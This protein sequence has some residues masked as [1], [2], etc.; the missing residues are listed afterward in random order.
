MNPNAQ[1]YGHGVG[2]NIHK[3]E[4]C[5]KYRYKMMGKDKYK[6]LCEDNIRKVAERHNIK[7]RELSVMPE[8]VHT[9]VE[10]P[11]TMS[12]VKAQQ[13]LKGG[14]S[15]EIFRAQPKFRLRYPRGSFWRRGKSSNTIG[16]STI[17]I[18]ENYVRKQEQHHGV[19]RQSSLRAY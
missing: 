17:E 11:M 2:T 10:L 1:T 13:I 3:I 14:S 9:T 19:W 5:T 6:T 8:H 16:Y 18:A 4:W 15:Y 12:P 7:I